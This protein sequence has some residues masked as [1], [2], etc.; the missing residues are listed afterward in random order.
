MP[1][2]LEAGQV[3]VRCYR[4]SR[5]Y[6]AERQRSVTLEQLRLWAASGVAVCVTDS[7]TGADITRVL[8][9]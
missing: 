1:E 3:V 2:V 7:E 5:L 8:L 9:V 6:D 4:R